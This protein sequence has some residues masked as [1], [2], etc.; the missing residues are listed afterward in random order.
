MGLALCIA[1]ALSF[2]GL[3]VGM[4]YGLKRIRIPL[5]SMGIIGLCTALAM[6]ISM[7][8]GHLLFSEVSI[9][10]SGS[11]GACILLFLGIYHLILAFR[12]RRTAK[13]VPAMASYTST[14]AYKVNTCK[15]LFSINLS[16]FGLVIQ[17]LKTPATADLDRSGTINVKESILLGIA[18]ALDSFAAGIAASMAGITFYV[19]VFVAILQ[20]FM[21]RVGQILTGR[22]PDVI[23]D[24]LKVVPGL[25]F[26]LIG[27]IKII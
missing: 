22:L 24:K 12:S 23:L 1:L 19:I 17:V 11:L 3:G 7:L 5:A 26:I 18:L 15:T 6:T 9:I 14:N 21:I 16:V 4:A 8:F 25:L 13:V 20:V 27:F 10:S 2:D